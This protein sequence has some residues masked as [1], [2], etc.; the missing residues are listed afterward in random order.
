MGRFTLKILG[1]GTR[2][3]D[4]CSACC[5]VSAI[6]ELDDKPGYA[7]CP[8]QAQAGCGIHKS[9]PGVCRKFQ[10]GWTMGIGKDRDRPDRLGVYLTFMQTPK[11]GEIARLYTT[12][13]VDFDDEK[14]IDFIGR[15]NIVTH[16]IV[17]GVAQAGAVILGGPSEMVT[18]YRESLRRSEAA[19]RDT[20]FLDL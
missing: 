1:R 15:A 14:V 17:I 11:F 9:R 3:C 7:P 18:R 10:C 4:G 6:K 20:G 16:Q 12:G 13:D 8:H 5:F 19:G 2:R